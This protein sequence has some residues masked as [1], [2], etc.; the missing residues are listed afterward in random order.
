MGMVN[1]AL[2]LDGGMKG[3]KHALGDIV[4]STEGDVY[5]HIIGEVTSVIKTCTACFKVKVLLHPT[6]YATER[7]VIPKDNQC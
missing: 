7:D 5:G 4:G 2:F 6:S 1:G 3:R